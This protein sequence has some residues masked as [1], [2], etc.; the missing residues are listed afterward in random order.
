MSRTKLLLEVVQNIQAL[1]QSLQELAEALM[2]GETQEIVT[3]E[4]DLPF[5]D[6]DIKTVKPK[7]TLEEVRA[8]LA[9]QSQAGFTAQ[10]QSIIQRFNAKKLSDVQS[11]YYEEIL[12]LADELSND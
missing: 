6:T 1:G 11:Q 7:V 8:V 3:K 5:D 2:V 12:L 10:V 4:D 9:R